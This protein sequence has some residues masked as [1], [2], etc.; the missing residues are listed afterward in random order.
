[1]ADEVENRVG[2]VDRGKRVGHVLTLPPVGAADAM[3][4]VASRSP[5]CAE[6]VR[7]ARC[8]PGAIPY[9]PSP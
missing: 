1:V 5:P 7:G 9:T 2:R 3:R 4:V 8:A 6:G